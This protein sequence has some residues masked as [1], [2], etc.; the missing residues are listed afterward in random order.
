MGRINLSAERMESLITAE[1]YYQFPGTMCT[2][3]CLTIGG[4]SVV[5][6]AH[7]ANPEEFDLGIG[8]R[9]AWADAID[10]ARPLVAHLDRER[11]RVGITL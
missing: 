5:G 1:S 10:K 6:E 2:V 11:M 4:S 3:C 9:S 8:Y 7:C